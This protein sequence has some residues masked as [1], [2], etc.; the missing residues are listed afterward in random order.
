MKIKAKVAVEDTIAFGDAMS[1][2]EMLMFCHIG[3]A[4]GNSKPELKEIADY[5]TTDV[6]DDGLWKAFKHFNLI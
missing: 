5:V 4:M 2:K 1:D 6:N 3:V